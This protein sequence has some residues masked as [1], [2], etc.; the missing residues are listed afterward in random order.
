MSIVNI[1]KLAEIASEFSLLIFAVGKGGL[2]PPLFP[3]MD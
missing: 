3:P 1:A 2:R